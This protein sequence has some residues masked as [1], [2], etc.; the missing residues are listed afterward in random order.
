MNTDPASPNLDGGVAGDV[1]RPSI[2][3]QEPRATRIARWVAALGSG[4]LVAVAS[5]PVGQ[6]WVQWFGFV[7]LLVALTGDRRTDARLGYACGVALVFANFAWLAETITLFSNL[8]WALAAVVVALFAGVWGLPYGLLGM[9]A[10]P[11][12]AHTGAAWPFVFAALWTGVE[13]VTPA[14]FPYYVAAPQY[15]TPWVWQLVSV[16]GVSSMTFLVV[17]LNATIAQVVR[18]RREGVPVPWRAATLVT[19]L[20]VGNLAFGAWRVQRVEATLASAP[21]L[22]AAIL[23]QGVS[24]VTRIQDRGMTVLRSWEALTARVVEQAPDLV[25]WPEGSIYYNPTDARVAKRFGD[26]TT[27]GGFAFLVGGGTREPDPADPKR[28]V[29]YNSAYL[30]DADGTISGRY[31]KMVPLPFGEYLP[32]P[33]SYLRGVI[34]GVGNFRAGTTP[35]TFRLTRGGWTFSTPICYEAILERAMRDLADVDLFVN[36]TND[37]WFGDTAAPHQHAMLAA[38]NAVSLGRPMLRIAYTG[39]SMVVEPHGAI[40]HETKPYTD[41]ATVVPVRMA[42]FETPYRTWGGAFP[43]AC[44]LVGAWAL[45]RIRP[46]RGAGARAAPSRPPPGGDLRGQGP[47]LA[48]AGS[49]PPS[50]D[51][52]SPRAP[53]EAPGGANRGGVPAT[54]RP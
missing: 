30:F 51:A 29:S 14:V 25:T 50:A 6:A 28:H 2:P 26:M 5:P 41:V 49:A 22:R 43:W 48:E 3:S 54:P 42:R 19:A 39:V 18:A 17:L 11:L 38:V 4:A 53:L 24:M 44:T 40:R 33:F 13:W 1:P 16:F 23:Q 12:R 34:E 21:T 27:S 20:F 47:A 7:P 8:P 31:D 45:W 15:R 46:A 37:G 52:S 9:A 35:T 10:A 32:W 36:I